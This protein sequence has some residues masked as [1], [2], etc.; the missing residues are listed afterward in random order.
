M[1][2]SSIDNALRDRTCILFDPPSEAAVQEHTQQ[3]IARMEESEVPIE[4]TPACLESQK[5][6]ELTVSADD[7]E[8]P[9]ILDDARPGGEQEFHAQLPDGLAFGSQTAYTPSEAV[10][11]APPPICDVESP[12][13]PT[14]NQRAPD[15]LSKLDES[16]SLEEGNAASLRSRDDRPAK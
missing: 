10:S 12:A 15:Y 7:W 9:A 2:D 13:S 5:S 6:P 11:M 4:A 3:L 16:L 14:S 1:A 8:E